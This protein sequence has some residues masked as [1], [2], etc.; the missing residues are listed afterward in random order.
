MGSEK[1]RTNNHPKKF[2][3]RLILLGIKTIYREF[4]QF[5]HSTAKSNR[6]SSEC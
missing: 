1:G 5:R 2:I 4:I 3:T 6:K